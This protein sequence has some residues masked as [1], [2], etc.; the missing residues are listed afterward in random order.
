M[1]RDITNYEY[2][3][4]KRELIRHIGQGLIS[5]EQVE[6]ILGTYEVRQKL[7]FIKVL[8]TLGAI[9]VGLGV[10]SFIASNWGYFSKLV[11]MLIIVAVY[12]GTGAA[13]VKV[14]ERYSKTGRSL[15]YLSMITYGAGLFLTGQM[16]NFGS[17]F[18][19]LAFLLWAVGILPVTFLLKD[20]L[21]FIFANVLF[22]LHINV[23][24]A[25]L[26]SFSWVMLLLVPMCYYFNR[27]FDQAVEVTFFNNLVA[28][29]A[30][31]CLFLT[32]VSAEAYVV[33]VLFVLGL[34]MYFVPIKF[35]TIVFKLQGILLLGVTGLILTFPGIWRDLLFAL[36]KYN[37]PSSIIFTI[38][39]VALL[40][41]ITRANNLISL[42]FICATIFRYYVDTMYDFL[43]KS[44]FFIVA[45]LLLLGFGYYFERARRK[46]GGV[47][48]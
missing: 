39:Y 33:P 4:L 17:T 48:A 19:Q 8:I 28:I 20:K 22:L 2:L 21:L 29:N 34:L 32:Q 18:N 44:V 43:P 24:F 14:S 10:L 9:L 26:N 27:Y 12:V 36:N 35:N 25:M 30:L 37:D 42:L 5:Q 23:H 41:F 47:V 16:F 1:K 3:F 7:N 31:A 46:Q 40:F 45:G 15:I 38:C 13:G 6:S 11:K